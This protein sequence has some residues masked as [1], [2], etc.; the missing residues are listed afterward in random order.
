[1]QVR[2]EAG[3][4]T[5]VRVMWIGARQVSLKPH[6]N[7]LMRFPVTLFVYTSSGFELPSMTLSQSSDPEKST[8][9]L[10]GLGG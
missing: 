7:R 8:Q 6:S 2:G 5:P 4:V 10:G 9:R 3:V 1:M